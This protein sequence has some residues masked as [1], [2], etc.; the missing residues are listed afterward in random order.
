MHSAADPDFTGL[1]AHL[2]KRATAMEKA[3]PEEAIRHHDS[4]V[5]GQNTRVSDAHEAAARM[6][7]QARS[8]R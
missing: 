3:K 6:R 1:P 2:Q 4:P 5:G 8:A 7:R